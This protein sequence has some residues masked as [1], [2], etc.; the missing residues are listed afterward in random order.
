MIFDINI[1]TIIN[2]P[3]NELKNQIQTLGKILRSGESLQ[4]VVTDGRKRH[5]TERVDKAGKQA[6]V[7]QIEATDLDSLLTRVEALNMSN[8][9]K[10]DVL[11]VQNLRE[12]IFAKEEDCALREKD[13]AMWKCVGR[14][15]DVS[16]GYIYSFRI[17]DKFNPS[18]D[19]NAEENIIKI[20]IAIFPAAE[21]T[22]DQVKEELDDKSLHQLG[23]SLEEASGDV[24]IH[25]PDRDVLMTKYGE[26]AAKR[27]EFVRKAITEL[28]DLR[29]NNSLGPQS[30]GQKQS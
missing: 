18:K 2:I 6:F 9:L 21:L 14:K 20:G 19:P 23:Y 16:G 25:L 12:N 11:T 8:E 10:T 3:P 28:K 13:S 30:H 7:T 1:S 4:V 5:I 27:S 26:V 22:L 15:K 29:E 17:L 24:I